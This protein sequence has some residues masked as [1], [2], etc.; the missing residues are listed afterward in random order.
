MTEDNLIGNSAL[1]TAVPHPYPSPAGRGDLLPSPPG[2]RAGDEGQPFQ[3]PTRRAIRQFCLAAAALLSAPAFALDVPAVLQWSQRVELSPRVSGVVESVNA[4]VGDRVKQGQALL[5]LDGRVYRA[6]QAES[7]AALRRQR[8]EAAEA[9]RDLG[10]MQE[11]YNRTVISISELDQAKLRH[12]QAQ[13]RVNEAAARLD[14]DRRDADDTTLRAPFDALVVDRRVETGQ[15]LVV[16]LQPQPVLVLAKAGE[17]VARFRLYDSQIG[18]LKAGQA[19]TVVVGSKSYPGTLRTLGL[20]PVMSKDGPTYPADVV[21]RTG[22]V[23]RAGTAAT[24]KL[25]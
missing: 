22:D 12:A 16:R 9:K 13:A 11:L 25:P 17:M 7:A 4:Q 21:F 20:E 8:E 10:R 6:R 23:L 2:R 18:P 3:F 24:V 15:N 5:T 14:Q 19:V 1:W